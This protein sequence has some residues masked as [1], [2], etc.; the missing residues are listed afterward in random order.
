MFQS[1][2]QRE[3]I[4]ALIQK[5]TGSQPVS[6]P[7]PRGVSDR[8]EFTDG[9]GN[10]IRMTVTESF[11]MASKYDG[12]NQ[13]WGTQDGESWSVSY[14]GKGTDPTWVEDAEQPYENWRSYHTQDGWHEMTIKQDGCIDLR[15]AVNAPLWIDGKKLTTE[16]RARLVRENHDEHVH[17]CD[18]RQYLALIQSVIPLADAWESKSG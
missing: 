14:P 1:R 5:T 11:G 18:A 13:M 7:L 6:V 8:V 3:N 4:D 12:T 15:N 9:D 16:E 2:E 10:P 17:I